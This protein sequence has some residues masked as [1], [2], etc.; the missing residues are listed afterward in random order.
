L[1]KKAQQNNLT[2]FIPKEN[3]YTNDFKKAGAKIMDYEYSGFKPNL[4][5]SIIRPGNPNTM[6][7]IGRSFDKNKHII[8]EYAGDDTAMLVQI[9][10][11]NY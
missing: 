6:I 7:A 10:Y 1:L 5:F 8:E 4:N 11:K 2:I 9:T 3:E